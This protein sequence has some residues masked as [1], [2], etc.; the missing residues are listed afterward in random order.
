MT[1]EELDGLRML[2][3]A[4]SKAPWK[5]HPRDVTAAARIEA[6]EDPYVVAAGYPKDD[7]LQ[8]FIEGPQ[9]PWGRG[10]FVS[11]DAALICALRNHAEEL[12]RCAAATRKAT[13]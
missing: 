6:G 12:L 2:L 11:V 3:D 1:E 8:W 4:A 10:E 5:P 13:S 7:F 9:E